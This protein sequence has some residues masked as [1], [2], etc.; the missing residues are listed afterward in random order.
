MFLE[1]CAGV[2]AVACLWFLLTK[3]PE[4]LLGIYAQPGK[5]FR[6]KKLLFVV[7]LNLRKRKAR[8]AASSVNNN[9]RSS[10]KGPGYGVKSRSTIDEM[11]CPQQLSSHENAIDCM[12]FNGLDNKGTYVIFR[13][14]RRHRR[15]AE[16]WLSVN[17]PGVGFFQSP[18]HPDT[19]VYNVDSDVYSAAGLK[20]ECLEPMKRWKVHYSGLMRKGMSSEY[21]TEPFETV[22]VQISLMWSAFTDFFDFDTDIHPNCISDAVAREKWSKDFFRRL[23]ASHQTHYEQWGELWGSF[24]V[25]AQPEVSLHGLRGYRDHSYGVRDWHSFHRYA[26][27]F[28]YLEDGSVFHVNGLSMPEG[29]SLL[30]CGYFS[31]PNAIM[32]PISSTD[33]NMLELSENRNPP[34]KYEFNFKA[35]GKNYHVKVEVGTVF[36]YYL[37][38][39]WRSVVFE[40]IS[41]YE[42]N[43]VK[44]YGVFEFLYRHPRGSP[45][46][47]Q[48][49]LP[50]LSEP[51]GVKVEEDEAL[52]LEFS[53][54]A[55]GASRL[56]GGKGCQLALLTQL[57][58]QEFIVP[59][60]FCLTV[61]AF[62]TQI[63][64]NPE[65]QRVVDELDEV[66]CT[67]PA[68]LQSYCSAAVLLFK[69]SALCSQVK[70]VLVQQLTSVFGA[71][72]DNIS[73]A[74][75]SSA[76]GEDGTEMSAAGQMETVLGVKG[77]EQ[78]CEAVS[79]CW[80]SQF[81]FPAV[82]YRRQH[83]QSIKL[84]AGVVIQAM[85]P[86]VAAGV[87]FTRHPVTGSPA[88][89]V[90]NANYG[91]G[92]SVVSGQSEPDE[93]L[94]GRTWDDKLSI[95]SKT[96]GHKKIQI[97]L[98]DAGDG[99][100]TIEGSSADTSSWCMLDDVALKLASIGVQ[101]E[102]RFSNPRDIEFAVDKNNNI[103]LLQARPITTIDRE[104]DEF[105]LH[106]FDTALA[107]DH[108]WLTTANIQE[109]MPGAVTP[110]TM[111]TFINA[112]DRAGQRSLI[113][114]GV[115]TNIH[116]PL[117]FLITWA[118]QSF[119]NLMYAMGQ[120]EEHCAIGD[121][122]MCELSLIGEIL[123]DL[124]MD[125]V[126]AYNGQSSLLRRQLIAVKNIL[127]LY[128]ASANT[129]YWM[130]K[131]KDLSITDS[132]HKSSHEV[133]DNITKHLP[134]LDEIWNFHM[135]ASTMSGLWISVMMSI[136][137]NNQHVWKPEHFSD[138]TVL[139]S[140]C[141]DV[142]S[143]D[144]PA[145]LQKLADTLRA[146]DSKDVFLKLSVEDAILWL[147]SAESGPSGAAFQQFLINHG[148]RC[149]REAE[150]RESSWRTDP[151]KIVKVI[152]SMVKAPQ[153]VSVG[154]ADRLTDVSDIKSNTNFIG[155]LVLRW[156]LPKARRAV[157]GRESAKS[158]AIK[159]TELF[160]QSYRKLAAMMVRE[161]RL[162][163]TDLIYFL[164]HREIGQVLNTGSGRL[165]ARAQRRRQLLSK[166][167]SYRFPR[168][169]TGHP[170][171]IQDDEVA[172][173]FD[174]SSSTLKVTGLPV[175]QGEIRGKA[176]V[177]T[178]LEEASEI[179]NGDILIVP[180][181]DVGWSPYFPMIS[182]LVTEI[183]SLVSHGAV[184][185]REYG[186]PCV[187][188][189]PRAT[190]MFKS[191][192]IVLLNGT[193]GTLEK[194]E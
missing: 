52:A 134:L 40:Q 22:H 138:V 161:S 53:S 3:D 108:E 128:R 84:S 16:I 89:M 32:T 144:V 26:I 28:A 42:V 121:K 23:E 61:R 87:L 41:S 4:P 150:M 83:G 179:Q 107:Y 181:T 12:Y 9:E 120:C 193:L 54:T 171:P 100:E 8:S 135:Q 162:P 124:T 180:Y 157:G 81:A 177:V 13:I 176:C 129:F 11:E 165:I 6:L 96:L 7:L 148:H 78:I 86:A 90:L 68:E 158:Q 169:F 18:I 189:I 64:N 106:E 116:Y 92:E 117:K 5:W 187:V 46:K 31:L 79:T 47:P 48:V 130:D 62:T 143:A 178:S 110:L 80:A 191:G 44:G 10:S 50:L 99:V 82:S 174:H 192:D 114:M 49:S 126:I 71:R 95:L 112:I 104:S 77:I 167:M 1:V 153:H 74:V 159:V 65:L 147:N 168:T 57:Q 132:S 27:N 58:S 37:H 183:G 131:L 101:L 98:K 20:F 172:N 103:Y 149:I 152:Q 56:V 14:A 97:R 122:R 38:E 75:R 39:D 133:Y 88:V 91:L 188:N 85:A 115:H 175:S 33:L 156:V 119:I 72:F 17:I 67:R 76:T 190:T 69:S 141:D 94:I 55:C 125:E 146:S 163:D 24:K 111:C 136:I 123:S 137:T 154:A 186:L 170:K 59:R 142:L 43:G 145:A 45:V 151:G 60:G 166:Q 15:M 182:G 36:L 127:R 155:R 185:A 139:L 35:G 102:K 21:T 160:K 34:K 93:I 66:S 30:Q 194:L 173:N 73:V 2:S 70:S 25:E 63:K 140:K 109:M 113:E 184:I 29:L 164:T 105:I 118:N 51:T 19:N